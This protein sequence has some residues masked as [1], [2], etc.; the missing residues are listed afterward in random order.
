MTYLC[1]FICP[2]TDMGAKQQKQ[3]ARTLLSVDIRV[4]QAH[5][6]SMWCI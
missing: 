1:A 3:H 2:R 4:P 5:S 6:P